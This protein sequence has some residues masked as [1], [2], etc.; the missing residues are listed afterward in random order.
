LNELLARIGAWWSAL[1]PAQRLRVGLSLLAAVAAAVGISVWASSASYKPVLTGA[2]YDDLLAAAAA[3]EEQ[4]IPYRLRDDGRLDVPSARLGGARAAIAS[5]DALPGLDDVSDLRLGLTPRAQEWALLR[6]LEGDLARMINGI[7]GVAAS[8]VQ[9]VPRREGLFLDDERPARASVFVRLRPGAALDPGQVRAI[10]S[11]VASAV[12]GLDAE[13]V[14]IAD[15]RGSLLARGRI[16]G[17]GT[18][19]PSDLLKYRRELQAEIEGA[20]TQALLPVLGAPTYFSV[21]AGVELDLA[22]TETV[23]KRLSVQEQ[24]VLSEQV[25][26][27]QTTRGAPRGVPGV[28]AN[29]PERGGAAGEGGQESA[30]SA[31][32]T[33]YVYPTVDEVRRLPAGGV[34]RL[35]VAVQVDDARIAQMVE[36]A[37][38]TPDAD[39]LRAAISAAVTAAARV[40]AERGDAVQVTYLPF[41]AAEWAAPETASVLSAVPEGVAP[42]AVAALAL[43]LAFLFVVRPIVSAATRPVSRDEPAAAPAA[44]EEATERPGGSDHELADRLVDLVESYQPMDT[45][46][47]NQLVENQSLAAAQVLRQWNRGA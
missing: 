20:V 19:D 25:Q 3:L 4:G 16:A 5:T 14:T 11:L 41:A 42:W 21:A 39:T 13:Q 17:G 43:V 26:E 30:K 31:L 24:A 33:N 27:S 32:V 15:D 12:D 34:R 29:R 22:S 36:A 38:G 47:L 9:I 40:D 45:T 18:G 2:S 35:S 7:D 46:L 23:S 8:Q 37:G 28:D 1:D 6:A 10:G 44:E